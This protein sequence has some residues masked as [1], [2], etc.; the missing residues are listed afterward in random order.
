MDA[1]GGH[2]NFKR[3]NEIEREKVKETLN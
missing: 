3:M 1:F 2:E